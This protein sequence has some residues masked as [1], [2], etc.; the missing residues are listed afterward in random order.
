M[1]DGDIPAVHAVIPETKILFRLYVAGNMPN[2]QRA[3]TNLQSFCRRELPHRHQIEIL[4]VF[5]VPN[6]ALEDRISLTPQL[7]IN[8]ALGV[9]RIA[10]DLSETSALFAAT[11]AQGP[12]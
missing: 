5:A 3:I 8:T 7:I 11:I 2:S 4:D 12:R 6:R 1:T 10:G 9:V